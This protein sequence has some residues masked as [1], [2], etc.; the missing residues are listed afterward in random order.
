M[1]TDLPHLSEA[2]L[3]KLIPRCR[4]VQNMTNNT[5]DCQKPRR[6][7]GS[8]VISKIERR[9]DAEGRIL[10]GGIS[11]VQCDTLRVFDWFSVLL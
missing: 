11:G 9:Y 3:R 5:T 4:E 8:P 10:K 2:K 6:R 1:A 7:I